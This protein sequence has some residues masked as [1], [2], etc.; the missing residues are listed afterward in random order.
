MDSDSP[1]PLFPQPFAPADSL[2]RRFVKP[3]SLVNALSPTQTHTYTHMYMQK[4]HT[5]L[6]H[7]L[8]EETKSFTILVKLNKA[9][10][11]PYH[12]WKY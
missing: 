8:S 4:T 9:L 3:K 1:R 7:F 12:P 6:F 2:H 10:R 5:D 11:F